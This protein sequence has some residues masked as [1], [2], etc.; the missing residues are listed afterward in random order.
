MEWLLL[1]LITVSF[2]KSRFSVNPYAFL[3]EIPAV[4]SVSE[5]KRASMEMEDFQGEQLFPEDAPNLVP[6]FMQTEEQELV[7]SDRGTAYHRFLEGLDY[8][9]AAS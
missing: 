8:G 6:A 2:V 1:E 3:Q 9:N 7:G 4:V 5:L